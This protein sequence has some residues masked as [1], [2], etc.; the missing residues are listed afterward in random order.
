MSRVEKLYGKLFSII[1]E[2]SQHE[3][4]DEIFDRIVDGFAYT[5]EEAQDR[6]RIY[7]DL[8]N[9]FRKN[10]L[11]DIPEAVEEDI[12]LESGDYDIYDSQVEGDRPVNWE[13]LEAN[14]SP[15]TKSIMSGSPDKF[16]EFL[17]G[18]EFPDQMG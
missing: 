11:A 17:K 18:I 15:S 5:V 1:E 7:S 6:E 4:A 13:A 16:L 9:M 2:L 10:D 8:L 3:T 14:L 12:N